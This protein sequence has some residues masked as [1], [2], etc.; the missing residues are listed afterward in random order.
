MTL[1]VD[2]YYRK[3]SE[4][5]DNIKMKFDISSLLVKSKEHDNKI[6]NIYDKDYIDNNFLIKSEIDKKDNNILNKINDNFYNRQYINDNYL[7]KGNTY[8]KK[9]IDD[10]F[11]IE[12]EIDNKDNEILNKINNNF[13]NRQYIND[14]YLL[15]SNIYDK[16][17]IDDNYFTKRV[18]NSSFASYNT[19]IYTKNNEILNKIKNEYY[20]KNELDTNF[21]NLYNRTYLDNKFD[22][23]YDK[24]EVNEKTSK[25]DRNLVLFNTNLTKFIDETYKNDK[26]ILEGDI[27]ENKSKFNNFL[28]KTFS[29]FSNNVTNLNNS[30]NS[31]LTDLENNKLT[32]IQTTKINQLT[33]IDLNKINSSYTNSVFNKIK[34]D[35]MRHYIKEFIP[36]NITLVRKFTFTG[37][38]N[39]IMVLQFEL[40]Q[41]E[42]DINDTFQFFLNMTVQFDNFKNSW[43]KIK[44]RLDVLYDDESIIKSFIKMPTSK[45][46]I[47]H[48]LM[49]F[50]IN[51]FFKLFKKTEKII[52]K[53]YIVKVNTALVDNIVFNLNQLYE[54]DFCDIIHYKTV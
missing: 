24:N 43:Y 11:L 29:A 52:F 2:K 6:E 25:L 13:Y 39:E 50:N 20:N 44:L 22:N 28:I 40:D 38:T 46:F 16:D 26:E 14:N 51:R 49:N 31:R 34:I 32:E 47:Y 21:N 18:L 7:I 41:R 12:S 10:N 9:Y 23:I 27:K 54:N 30:Q 45:G 8:D 42:F 36:F 35:K 15:K 3:I 4:N 17:Y 53:I 48:H 37:N 5:S 19:K 1:V 33:N